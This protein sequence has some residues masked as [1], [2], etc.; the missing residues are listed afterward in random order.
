MGTMVGD[1]GGSNQIGVA[2]G[3]KWIGCRNMDQGNGTPITYS[4]CYQWFV[5]PTDLAG[6]NPDPSKAPDV[7]NNS[8]GCPVSEGCVDPNV[9][10][11]VVDNLRAAGIVTVHSAGNSGPGCNSVT[12][13]AAI[14][15]S[16]FSVGATDNNDNIASFSSR[17]PVTVDGSN[18]L[19]PNVSAPGVNVRSSFPGTGYG[20]LSGTS[21]AGPHVVGVVALVMSSDPALIGDPAAVESLLEIS[22]VPRTTTQTCGGVPGSSIPNNTFGFG[23][24]D[25]LNAYNSNV[26]PVA[27]HIGDLDARTQNS[28]TKWGIEVTALVLDAASAPVNGAVVAFT[29]GR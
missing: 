29:G 7:I 18:R 20:S 13:P 14:Y 25:A 21:M 19:K 1:D 11:T 16:S 22:A 28:G 12:D 17:G 26:P 5:A 8:W 15:A 24:V 27:V 6:N 4:E 2:P 3:A 9:L 23:R 10:L